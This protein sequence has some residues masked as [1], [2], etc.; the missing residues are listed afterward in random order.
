GHD[1][2]RPIPARP[3]CRRSRPLGTRLT[4]FVLWVTAGLLSGPRP[5]A[6]SP[7][8]ELVDLAL[9]LA[10]MSREPFCAPISVRSVAGML[11]NGDPAPCCPFLAEPRST[12]PPPSPCL[13]R[14]TLP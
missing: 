11:D 3:A 7:A 2:R 12:A 13:P 14:L 10:T 9:L 5:P 1:V 4:A 6:F 8:G